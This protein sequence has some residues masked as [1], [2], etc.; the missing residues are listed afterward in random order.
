MVMNMKRNYRQK[1]K[2]RNRVMAVVMAFAM[3]LS[4]LCAPGAD[5]WL[6][7]AFKSVY[8]IVHAASP[9]VDKNV[10]INSLYDLYVFSMKYANADGNSP[11][12]ANTYKNANLQITINE[13]TLV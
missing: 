11:D 9:V 4:V 3:I 6:G 10:K 12:Y 5:G 7:D 2:L 13:R 1:R 8:G